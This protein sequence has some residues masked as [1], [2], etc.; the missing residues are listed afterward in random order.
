VSS[1]KGIVVRS[2]YS[3]CL[4][5]AA[6]CL[7]I[8]VSVSTSL[9]A[10]ESNQ[11]RDIANS[12]IKIGAIRWDAWY[13]NAP[14]LNA[15]SKPEWLDR[16]PFF[17]RRSAD[18]NLIL[19]GDTEN[20]LSAEVAYAKSIG[21]DYFIFGFYPDTSS[22]KRDL[23]I[24]LE[25]NRALSS[26]LH[27]SDRLGVKFAV[28]LNQSFPWEDVE[29]IALTL[30]ELAA[31]KDY[32][33]THQNK[34]PIFI[35]G[36]EG[37][38][39]PVYGSDQRVREVISKI[40]SRVRERTG[41]EIVFVWL[42][43]D[44]SLAWSTA[45][46]YG[47]DSVSAYANFS[48][49]SG[50]KPQPADTCV[51]HGTNLWRK[52]RAAGIPYIPNIS[53]GWDARPRLKQTGS[54][55]PTPTGP[56]CETLTADLLQKYFS[57]AFEYVRS[58][59]EDLPFRSIIIYAWNEYAEGGWMAPTIGEGLTRLDMLAKAIGRTPPMPPVELTW[60]TNL[61][62]SS[63]PIRTTERVARQVELA[64]NH[65]TSL[66]A[67]AWPCPPGTTV[68]LDFVRAPTGLEARLWPGA[69]A[70]RYCKPQ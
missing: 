12:D 62:A 27:L 32:V 23:G 47:L 59:P 5:T 69:W 17:A 16:V 56:W 6:M 10:Q 11:A 39:T 26:Y 20:V 21:L 22:W 54:E 52:A 61:E 67:P 63:C 3:R 4:A 30:A 65:S 31:N 38:W 28:S 36:Q 58:S 29:D 35:F 24:Q 45:Q 44:S 70:E 1:Q 68:D 18:G 37:D 48:P 40:R 13:P 19:D 66:S 41:L 33:R 60:P 9:S 14:D 64:C 55:A 25:L 53:L 51:T 43:Y 42:H 46:R 2:K 49:G 57:G 7:A 15:I 50:P 34:I 8:I